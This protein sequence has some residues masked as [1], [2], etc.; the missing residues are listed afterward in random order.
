MFLC[1]DCKKVKKK[2]K[3]AK[4]CR[5]C[6]A[7][8][9]SKGNSNALGHRKSEATN[10]LLSKQAIKQ[11]KEGRGV[12]PPPRFGCRSEEE[13]ENIRQASLKAW[14]DNPNIGMTGKTHNDSTKELMREKSNGFCPNYN[15]EAC[16]IIDEYGK[17]HGY[18]FQHAENGGEV[19][20]AGYYLDGY[21][22]ENNVVIEYYEKFHQN[23][24]EEDEIRKR[25]IIE[26]LGCSFI[27]IKEWEL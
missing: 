18:N 5:S 16:R 17:K 1:Q 4:R 15:P 7:K 11:W 9:S 10:Q 20:V 14:H 8:I 27:E 22:K 12:P 26:K 21:D 19:R 13:K 3:R 24:I 23:Q 2:T 25:S 6:A